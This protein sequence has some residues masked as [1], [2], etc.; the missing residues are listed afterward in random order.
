VAAA[1]DA[2]KADVGPGCAAPDASAG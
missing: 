1:F 2:L